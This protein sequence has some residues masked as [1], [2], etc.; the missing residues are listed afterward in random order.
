MRHV[1]VDRRLLRQNV[2]TDEP[3][4][5]ARRI[6]DLVWDPVLIISDALWHIGPDATAEQLRSYLVQSHGF[7]GIN[8][9]YDFH[10]GSQRGIGI[11]A[12]I[13]DRWD[14]DKNDVTAVSRGGGIPR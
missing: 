7:A 9:L 10:D 6:D 14:K 2:R 5:N 11:G 3:L 4:T 1:D 8:G 13:I 12:V